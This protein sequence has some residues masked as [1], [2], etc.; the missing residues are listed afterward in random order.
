[1]IINNKNYLLLERRGC[2]Y[3]KDDAGR[4]DIGNYRVGSYENRISAK[5]GNDYILEFCGYD[6]NIVRRTN[7]RTG[8]P[9]KKPII[10]TVMK[11]ALHVDT[12]F[13]TI[14]PGEK[15]LSSW[16]NSAL[17][18]EYRDTGA[19]PYC[20]ASILDFVNSISVDKYDDIM[21]VETIETTRPAALNWRP[22]DLVIDY[23]K[24]NNK[25]YRRDKYGN[26]YIKLYTGEYKYLCY[27]IEPGNKDNAKITIT[28]ER[29]EK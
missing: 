23:A 1:M 26:T 16:R 12:E 6:Y 25:E 19:H 15:F 22:A 17:E 18:K 10:E 9:L 7:K 20:R 14:I 4:D 5:D 13:E 8:A 2:E 28:L 21:F 27:S 24:R 3:F 29:L 11:N